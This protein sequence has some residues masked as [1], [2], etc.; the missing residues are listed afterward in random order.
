MRIFC[1]I[2][3]GLFFNTLH[4]FLSFS[5]VTCVCT[6]QF[7]DGTNCMPKYLYSSF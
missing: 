7:R 5:I 2:V 6:F 3:T 4:Y 1:F